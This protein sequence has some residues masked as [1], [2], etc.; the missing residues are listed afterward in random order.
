MGASDGIFSSIPP[1]F[2]IKKHFSSI[3]IEQ[4]EKPQENKTNIQGTFQAP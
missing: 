1:T 4:K 3:T 2:S